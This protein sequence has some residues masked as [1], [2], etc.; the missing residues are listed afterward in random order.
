VRPHPK[1]QNEPI[2]FGEAAPP[3]LQNEPI[4]FGEAAPPKLQNEPILFGEATP[5][6]AK[7]THSVRLGRSPNCKTNPFHSV[8]PLPP[9]AKRTQQRPRVNLVFDR[10]SLGPGITRSI[11]SGAESRADL[12]D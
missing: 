6:I 5:P 8:R 1:L 12:V 11:E 7:R 2:L 9:I 3:K 10:G 4:L